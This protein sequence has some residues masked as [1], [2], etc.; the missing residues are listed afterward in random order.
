MRALSQIPKTAGTTLE[1]FLRIEFQYHKSMRLKFGGHADE[2]RLT[3]FNFR[4]PT[5]P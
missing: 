4:N 3:L 1:H 5:P 2:V